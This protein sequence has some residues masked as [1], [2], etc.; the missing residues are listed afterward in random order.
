MENSRVYVGNLGY[1]VT[2]QQL[3]ELFEGFGTTRIVKHNQEKGWAFVEFDSP[4]EARK[5]ISGLQNTEFEG[6]PI[7][8]DM[9]RPFVPKDKRYKD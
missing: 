4:E 9:A 5:A 8:I 6:R 2:D 1:E 7:K 3:I